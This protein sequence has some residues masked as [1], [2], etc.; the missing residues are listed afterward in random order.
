MIPKLVAQMHLN[1]K[2]F[3]FK[4]IFQR[5]IANELT[6][7]PTGVVIILVKNILRISFDKSEFTWLLTSI[8]LKCIFPSKYIE[9]TNIASQ[10]KLN[11]MI[12]RI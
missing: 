3:P 7:S 12:F 9:P 1:I 4:K 2:Y 8:L 11:Q 10:I 5:E 6:K